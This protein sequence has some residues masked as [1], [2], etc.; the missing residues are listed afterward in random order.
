MNLLFDTGA[1]LSWLANVPELSA[2]LAGSLPRIHDDPFDRMPMALVTA[3]SRLA[4][5]GVSV[6]H[7]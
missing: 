7:A 6:I 2:L 3:G 4:A 1:L 5:Y